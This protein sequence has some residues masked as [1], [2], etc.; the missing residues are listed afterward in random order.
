MKYSNVAS[1]MQGVMSFK[2][3][4]PEE[5]AHDLNKRMRGNTYWRALN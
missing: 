5:N 3:Q 1:R 4:Q 2:C